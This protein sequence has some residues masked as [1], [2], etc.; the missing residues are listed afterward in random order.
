MKY[1]KINLK[2]NGVYEFS[3]INGLF[4]TIGLSHKTTNPEEIP[5]IIANIRSFCDDVPVYFYENGVF[6]RKE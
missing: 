3:L 6:V 1:I 2:R 4:I 5:A